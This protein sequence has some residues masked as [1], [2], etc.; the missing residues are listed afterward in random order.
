MVLRWLV[1][2]LR[3]KPQKRSTD[4]EKTKKEQL[5]RELRKSI[6]NLIDNNEEQWS[7]G[8]RL[9]VL[10]GTYNVGEKLPDSEASEE[11]LNWLSCNGRQEEP[12]IIALGLQEVDMSPASVLLETLSPKGTVWTQFIE[13]YLGFGLENP[14]Y[15]AAQ[16][17]AVAGLLLL[18]YIK[19]RPELKHTPQDIAHTVVRTGIRGLANKG[20]VAVRIR[21]C[22]RTF[23][24]VNSHLEAHE[25]RKEIRDDNY[26]SILHGLS[27]PPVEDGVDA[28][29][30]EGSD[31][32]AVS[33]CNQFS[34]SHLSNIESWDYAFWFGDLNYR[35]QGNSQSIRSRL[36]REQASELLRYDEL[37]HT[38]ACGQAF[39]GWKEM[40]INFPPTYK[41]V[42]GTNRYSSKR[43]PAWTDRILY[44][45]GKRGRLNTRCAPL[46]ISIL[47][48]KTHLDPNG[49]I[50]NSP[51]TQTSY[52]SCSNDDSIAVGTRKLKTSFMNIPQGDQNGNSAPSSRRV[53]V[54]STSPT[55]PHTPRS[56]L[57]E[58]KFA[59]S[60]LV[61][62]DN[63]YSS[64]QILLSDHRPVSA[65]FCVK[66][67]V[68]DVKEA[69][70][71]IASDSKI[72]SMVEHIQE[73]S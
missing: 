56:P 58:N 72:R 24:F 23:V 1:E 48:P 49:Y 9:N 12:D 2:K 29:C 15:T 11:V 71:G 21:L 5:A 8:V 4:A 37:S 33:V 19:N 42:E 25:N 34:T 59:F 22:N 6:N 69:V 31:S 10:V 46:T 70:D 30:T 3:S 54:T 60:H 63:S 62:V 20:G 14:P 51:Q 27:F 73:V 39:S 47:P 16:P 44:W 26:A 7:T 61:P 13:S 68:Y 65:A 64:H 45:M 35:L 32:I 55:P 41:F 36:Q 67:I 50:D 43:T 52:F 38:T 66:G 53:S 40:A 57:T 17:I 28:L 18:I